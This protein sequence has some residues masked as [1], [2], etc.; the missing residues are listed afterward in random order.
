FDGSGRGHIRAGRRCLSKM[1]GV[2][3]RLRGI[4][5][6]RLRAGCGGLRRRLSR[7]IFRRVFPSGRANSPS[8]QKGQ[9]NY[10]F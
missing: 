10:K 9:E 2:G 7:R 6:G 8:A 1:I 5:F 3:G 4:C